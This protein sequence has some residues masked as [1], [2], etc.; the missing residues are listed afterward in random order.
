MAE[1]RRRLSVLSA[2]LLQT[3]SPFLEQTSARDGLLEGQVAIVTGSGQGIGEATAKLFAKEGAKVVVTDLDAEKSNRVAAEI[4]AAGGVA[5]SV[6]GDITAKEFPDKLIQET[7][8]AFE[9]LHIL[10]NNAG[11]TWDGMLHRMSDQQWEAMLM[12]HNTAPFRLIRAAAPHMRD[13]AKQEI[14]SGGKAEPRS[15]VNI[16]S[17]SGLHGNVGQ[18]NYSTAKMG[19]LGLSKTISKEWGMFNIRCNAVAFGLID[20]RLTRPRDS[21]NGVITVQ[22]D[23]KTAVVKLGIPQNAIDPNRTQRIPLRRAGTAEDAA[24][25]ILLMCSPLAS[26]IT[27]HCL[28]VTGGI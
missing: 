19:V 2:H 11:Y 4:K 17:T 6:P 8:Q 23:D 22:H 18:A 21:Q 15:I 9:K 27:G 3:S 12:V 13:A 5:I 25:G 28:E 24:G 1:V 10:V 16:S 20:T 7:I 14:D 26:Y